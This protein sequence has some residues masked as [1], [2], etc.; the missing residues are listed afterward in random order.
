MMLTIPRA[1]IRTAGNIRIIS[2]SSFKRKLRIPVKSG[3]QNSKN[4]K[5]IVIAI[6][7]ILLKPE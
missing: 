4:L 6:A 1:K 2:L 3:S 5:S 7:S